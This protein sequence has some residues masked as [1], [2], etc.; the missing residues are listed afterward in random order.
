MIIEYL[1]KVNFKSVFN[2]FSRTLN[3]VR[4]NA[5]HI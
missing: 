1:E 4:I 5:I 3:D 2:C